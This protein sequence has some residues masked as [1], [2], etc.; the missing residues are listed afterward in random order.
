MPAPPDIKASDQDVA[1]GAALYGRFCLMCH[2]VAAAGGAVADLRRSSRL[3]DAP[4]WRQ[5]TV[6][7][8][9]AVGMPSFAGDVSDEEAEWIRAYVAKQAA[10]A[11][12]A[13][14]SGAKRGTGH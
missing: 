1:R 13:E 12:A 8:I 2:G 3:H 10:A 7:G 14:Q 5:V 6:G 11:Y 4:A 9:T